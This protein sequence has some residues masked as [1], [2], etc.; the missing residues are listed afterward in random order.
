MRF[1]F[2]CIFYMTYVFESFR[3]IDGKG[4]V[5]Q[6]PQIPKNLAVCSSQR[7]EHA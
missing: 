4:C 6:V 5:E 2:F 7:A 1:K 3:L